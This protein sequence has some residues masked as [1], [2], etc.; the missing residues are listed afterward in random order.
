MLIVMISMIQPLHVGNAIR[1][2]LEPPANAV[3]W[4]VL[5]KGSGTFP[6]HDDPS[7]LLA[8]QGDEN[9]IVD[10]SSL[11]NEVLQFYCAFYTADRTTWTASNVVS[12]TPRANYE[13]HTTD[14]LSYLRDRLQEGLLVECQR[15]NF[16]TELGYIQVYT[17]PPSLERDLRFPLVTLHLE[18]EEP[19]ERG[20]GETISGDEFDAIGFDWQESEGWLAGV[21]ITIVG[22]SLN[23]DERIELRRAIRRLIVG[24]LPVFDSLG[25]VQVGLSQ[26]DV[27]AINGEYPSPIYQVMSMFS[28]IAPVRVSGKVDAV[29]QVQQTIR[30]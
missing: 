27:D 26:Q 17:A 13:D 3:E 24:N 6:G 15:G 22:W 4:K 14:V 11:Q 29:S 9:V 2:F 16:Q 21:R 19:A 7:A 18:S 1:L 23:S 5:R 10:V 30:S 25:W 20:L 12:A 28:C 8:Y